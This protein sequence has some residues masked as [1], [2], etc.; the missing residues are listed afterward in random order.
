MEFLQYNYGI[1]IANKIKYNNTKYGD[2]DMKKTLFKKLLAV[3]LAFATLTFA[4]CQK[5]E[6]VNNDENPSENISQNAQT[7]ASVEKLPV[8]DNTIDL[9]G[10]ELNMEFNIYENYEIST[11]YP[12]ALGTV[13]VVRE[14]LTEKMLTYLFVATQD[15]IKYEMVSDMGSESTTYTI[16][17]ANVDNEPGEE[18][19]LAVDIGSTFG[20]GLWLTG[21]YKITEKG[22]ETI[23]MDESGYRFVA[24]KPFK[25]II[26]NE[27]TDLNESVDVDND[28]Y[29]FED[30]GTPEPDA[31]EYCGVGAWDIRP[32]DVD[33]DGDYEVVVRE[34]CN[35]SKEILDT[36]VD[37]ETV[38]EFD[39]E[40]NKFV[41]TETSVWVKDDEWMFD[42]DYNCHKY[43]DID[44][45]GKGEFLALTCYDKENVTCNVYA[46]EDGKLIHAG[47]IPC[48]NRSYFYDGDGL[49]TESGSISGKTW[50]KS[51]ELVNNKLVL[52]ESNDSIP[53]E[54]AEEEK[55]FNSIGTEIEWYCY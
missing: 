43:L 55:L 47:E 19:L 40:K 15:D 37:T 6:P 22:I 29:S 31:T 8:M 21:V 42:L 46:I 54:G 44:E 38:Y 1:R 2:E 10:I 50:Y 53:I 27:Y 36:S 24:E 14:F 30:D 13:Y 52:K 41:V 7:N 28:S 45:D 12:T 25:Y 9:R 32:E 16:F 48:T 18:I 4:G 39:A 33:E 23:E 34:W 26:T 17:T 49:L 51:Y 11:P 35:I 5:E 20:R 3:S